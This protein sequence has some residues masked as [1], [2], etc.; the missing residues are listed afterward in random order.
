MQ[1]DA[2]EDRAATA[3]ALGQVLRLGTGMEDQSD[4][5]EYVAR[6]PMRQPQ[7]AVNVLGEFER[8]HRLMGTQIRQEEG[9]LT[10]LF[11][12][13]VT[14]LTLDAPATQMPRLGA[15]LL[16]MQNV[17]HLWSTSRE[18]LDRIVDELRQRAGP[19]LGEP[20][21]GRVP[22]N[23]LDVVSDALAFPLNATSQEDARQRMIE[24]MG[25]YYEETWIHQP[26]LALNRVPPVDAA[27]HGPLRKKLRGVI[28][29]L[30]E[31]AKLAA[32]DYD[33]D[34]LRRK[35][36]VLA[37][38]PAAQ[39][40]PGGAADFGA[41]SAAELAGVA[42]EPLSDAQLE[43]AFQAALK[44]DAQ[45]LAG[46]FAK[47][48]VGRPA[49]AERPDR[50]RWF[51]H[52]VQQAAS[53]GDYAAALDFLNEGEKDDC[54]HNEGR[55]RNDYEL[56]RAQLHAK[57]GDLDA[58]QGAFEK[59]IERAPAELRYRSTAAETML[60]A[61]QGRG[62]NASR[63]TAWPRLDGRTT[64]IRRS[65]SRNWWRRR[66]GTSNCGLRTRS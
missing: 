59:L 12:E 55:R 24:H 44:L 57:S 28:Q 1:L 64:A 9:V 66:S 52:L 33:F 54:E 32:Y 56:R 29:F 17:F 35:L 18:G 3:W 13:K 40:A 50:Y 19:A 16:V 53:A 6:L 14:G 21:R 2:D 20:H 65:T 61:R 4:Y 49:A 63:R 43:E 15:H 51:A 36:G 5:V 27:G 45:D 7:Q 37:G 47:G 60:S 11:L 8:D 62:P 25:R 38:V 39:A 30:Q 34:R 42:V 46:K 31:C 26:L 10:S 48:L 41:I 58:A 22:A 23:F